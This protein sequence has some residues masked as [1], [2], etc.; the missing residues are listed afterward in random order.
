MQDESRDE[1]QNGGADR[2]SDAETVVAATE[3]SRGGPILGPLLIDTLPGED[4]GFPFAEA[5]QGLILIGIIALMAGILAALLSAHS[6]DMGWEGAW[7]VPRG[8]LFFVLPMSLALFA[9]GTLLY[10]FG[11]RNGTD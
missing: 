10:F 1:H 5:G 2:C 3:Q 9:A 6:L 7:Y 4:E 8:E 11:R